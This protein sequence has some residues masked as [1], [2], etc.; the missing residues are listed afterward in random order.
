MVKLGFEQGCVMQLIVTSPGNRLFFKLLKPCFRVTV[1]DLWFRE[2][3]GARTHRKKKSGFV[4]LGTSRAM[5]T[6][7]TVATFYPQLFFEPAY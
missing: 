2:V 5:R 4:K 7:I 6:R 3:L 1:S